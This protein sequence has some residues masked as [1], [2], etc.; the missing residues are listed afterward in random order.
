ME[1]R[2]EE[3]PENTKEAAKEAMQRAEEFLAQKMQQQDSGGYVEDYGGATTPTV[4]IPPTTTVWA[5]SPEDDD[6][7]AAA[8]AAAEE[9]QAKLAS[10]RQNQLQDGLMGRLFSRKTPWGSGSNS[11]NNSSQHSLPT[12][13]TNE[14]PA[15]RMQRE[16]DEINRA[17]AERQLAMNQQEM[18]AHEDDTSKTVEIDKPVDMQPPPASPSWGKAN[19]PRTTSWTRPSVAASP[20]APPPPKTPSEKLNDILHNF[21]E[22]VQKAMNRVAQMRD[23]HKGLLDER[24]LALAKERLA[25]QSM[26][27]AEA[28]QMQAAESEDYDLA[29]RLGAV[30]NGHAREKAEL[31][32][33]L[34]NI[35]R[36]LAELDSQKTRVVGEVALCFERVRDEL[37]DFQEEQKSND[38]KDD[39]ESMEKFASVAKHLSSEQARLSSDEKHLLRD[40]KL[41]QEE[42]KELEMSISEQ[43]ADIEKQ[44]DSAR[45]NLLTIE[46]EIEVLRRQL[47]AK[48]ATAKGLRAEVDS[49]ESDINRIRDK[50]SRQLTRVEKKEASVKE[51][52]YEWEKEKIMHDTSKLAHEKEVESHHKSLIAHEALME[53]LRKE[54]ALADAFK[55]IVAAEVV[56][57]KSAEQD[58][59]SDGDFAQLQA[60]V[61]KSE[62]AVSE[63]KQILKAAEAALSDLKDERDSLMK[64][65]PLLEEEKTAAAARRD[66]KAAGSANKQI[67]DATARLK[68]CQE[69]LSGEARERKDSALDQLVSLEKDLKEKK[70]VLN[71][72]EKEAGRAAMEKVAEKVKRLAETKKSVCGGAMDASGVQVVGA[73]VLNGQVEALMREGS[74][75]GEKYG[76][77]DAIAEEL[78][79]SGVLDTTGVTKSGGQGRHSPE[80]CPGRRPPDDVDPEVITKF[81]L[82]TRRLQEMEEAIDAAVARDDFDTAEKLN[83]E[84]EEIKVEWE[85][86]D[87]T[88]AEIKIFEGG[89]ELEETE[90]AEADEDNPVPVSDETGAKDDTSVDDN[91]DDHSN[92]D[93]SDESEHPEESDGGRSGY[94]SEEGTD[95]ID[96]SEP[97]DP[98]FES[99]SRKEKGGA[100]NRENSVVPEQEEEP[101]QSASADGDDEKEDASIKTDE[102][103]DAK[104][105]EVPA[106]ENG[107]LEKNDGEQETDANRT[108]NSEDQATASTPDD[109]RESPAAENGH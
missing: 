81:R 87:L 77:W 65:I 2:K 27:T 99:S 55:A 105:V 41:V 17:M 75:Y 79:K 37:K 62:A 13:T 60:D 35:G 97:D 74:A 109:G 96:D 33:I 91:N 24:L 70:A 100:D 68:E 66:F 50:F 67:K 80:V 46:E 72:Q 16:Q 85:A 42:R 107:T 86:I 20:P 23:H 58:L 12:V 54:I 90:E 22:S 6:D 61:V 43:T 98:Q 47:E 76:G 48:E 18:P 102:E 88:E 14:T 57:E 53:K 9:A 31:T 30:I 59:E 5:R 52:R 40:E 71:E 39:T 103:E 4:V 19:I 36:A 83:Q 108:T 56:F 78:T 89:E 93:S 101:D 63:G 7:Y 84:L 73:F 3:K 82:A 38:K 45:A 64:Q 25:T 11:V 51:N 21:D 92:D 106:V 1:Q 95:L 94:V 69:K 28:Q 34:D 26:A 15:E 10:G 104:S 49:H 8:K 32:A 29:D 44:R